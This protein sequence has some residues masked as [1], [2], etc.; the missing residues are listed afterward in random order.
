M[1]KDR[2]YAGLIFREIFMQL[3]KGCKYIECNFSNPGNW[4]ELWPYM[5]RTDH[6]QHVEI[7][8]TE[9][10]LA[11]ICRELQDRPSK[12]SDFNSFDIVKGTKSFMHGVDGVSFY[13]DPMFK[14]PE[15][16]IE[17]AEKDRIFFTITEELPHPW[18]YRDDEYPGL[19][20]HHLLPLLP[21]DCRMI[22]QNFK[23]PDKYPALKEYVTLN[24]DKA[25]VDLSGKGKTVLQYILQEHPDIYWGFSSFCILNEEKVYVKGVDRKILRIL[26][27]FTVS[28][29]YITKC[30]NAG[31]EIIFN[32]SIIPLR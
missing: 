28:D 17:K 30:T 21:E 31:I 27:M 12:F 3:P 6:S 32:S 24:E 25:V 29:E 15:E 4:R 8:L 18:F 22:I 14:I 13:V 20:I 5:K 9:K 26:S 7:D 2:D 23:N 10:A 1:E 19:L 16:W 11:V